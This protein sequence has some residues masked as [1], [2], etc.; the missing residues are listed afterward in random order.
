MASYCISA[1]RQATC[2]E[3]SCVLGYMTFI[4]FIGKLSAATKLQQLA[5]QV[6]LFD[7][8]N[9]AALSRQFP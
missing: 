8:S 1:N 6:K 3:P 7:S 2:W 4:T 9:A 5:E